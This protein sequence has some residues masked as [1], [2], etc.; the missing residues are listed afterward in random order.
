MTRQ[1][2]TET[3]L[4]PKSQAKTKP[5]AAEPTSYQVGLVDQLDL[6]GAGA[7]DGLQAQ[8]A[9]LGNPG[10]Q[11]AQRQALAAQIGRGQGNQHLQRVMASMQDGQKAGAAAGRGAKPGPASSPPAEELAGADL[12]EAGFGSSG[13]P[14]MAAAQPPA[15]KAA[16]VM[17]QPGPAEKVET[18]QP[19]DPQQTLNRL[20]IQRQGVPAPVP[21][22]SVK[23][24]P[25]A[26]TAGTRQKF[27][28][29]YRLS[30]FQ[31]VD[32]VQ[33]TFISHTAPV[34]VVED[35]K[36]PSQP[37]QTG[38]IVLEAATTEGSGTLTLGL[39]Y[40]GDS[41]ESDPITI[42]V[43]AGPVMPS[44]PNR[45]FFDTDS[46]AIRP[47]AATGLAQVA[48]RLKAE[49]DLVVK[50][51]GHADSR[52]TDEYNVKLSYRRAQSARNYL[53]TTLGVKP[54]RVPKEFVIG[55]GEA[56]PAIS[57][58]VN[59]SDF[60][61]NRRVELIF[62][63]GPEAEEI[64]PTVR[65]NPSKVV[66]EV[67]KQFAL[68]YEV[69]DVHDTDKFGGAALIS[70]GDVHRVDGS[71]PKMPG[72]ETGV[73]TME[74]GA[75]PGKARVTVGITYGG[76]NYDS[77]PVEVEIVQ[78]PTADYIVPF[79][80]NP[81]SAPGE[82]IIFNARLGHAQPA[83]F[84]L[85]YA[86]VGGGF[87]T[88][89]GADTK[90]IPGLTSGN[91]F[92]FINSTWDGTSPVTVQL[93]VQ[94]IADK[95]IFHTFNWTFNQKPYF[96]TTMTQQQGEGERPL[97][98]TYGYKIGPDRNADAVDDYVHQTILE[99]FEQRS[100]NITLAE[101]KPDFKT[102]HPGITGPEQITAHFFGTSSNNGT[103]TVSAGDMIFDQHG[104]GM[105]DLAVFEAALIT[106]KEIFVD[107]P[108]IYEAEPGVVLGRY[109]IR[110]IL[111]TDRT[112]KLRKM[113]Q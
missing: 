76:A 74:A 47:D 33:A 29:Q 15:D 31:E 105:P 20:A 25:L 8:A 103:F 35:V 56:A 16:G 5:A 110:R 75:T 97:P 80:R 99:R 62:A 40:K 53:I 82:R 94:R 100:C 4:K 65:L 22:P 27:P 87:E 51:E 60:Q 39:Q 77:S 14:S 101:L 66:T 30:N 12:F 89:G 68:S 70:T 63:K 2:K 52:Y 102:A 24:S 108:Q 83:D 81:L 34:S 49:P 17:L 111:K 23:I 1:P 104:G 84:Q 21:P 71:L 7:G 109:L 50:L 88:A 92:F 78:L 55:R 44:S 91:L 72:G 112:K 10:L 96:P 106:M 46:D 3:Q 37:N 98:S 113:K 32:Q 57:P 36:F 38:A 6:S 93:Q 61:L 45:I 59:P 73:L 28:L 18:G 9:R 42:N 86:G 19:P 69:L 90:T 58:E 48:E 11:L 54:K 67:G 64:P 43:T 13:A 26:M 107:L 79:D 95:T 41:I 85:V